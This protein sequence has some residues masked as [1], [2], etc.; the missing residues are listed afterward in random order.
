[1]KLAR[2]MLACLVTAMAATLVC[3]GEE[4]MDIDQL[5]DWNDP[6]ASEIRFRGALA[7]AD[8]DARL[9]LLTQVARTY[10]LRRQ[11]DQAHA[12]LDEVQLQ[13]PAAGPRVRLRYL[14]ERGRSFN[15][16]GERDSARAR[17]VEAWE[18]GRS[19][20]ADALAIDAAHMVAITEDD[21]EAVAWNQRALEIATE[22]DEPKAQRWKGA[23]LNNLAV[24]FG[25]LG[26]W[27]E[28][29]DA[30][31]LSHDEYLAFGDAGN[32]R[33]ARWMVAHAQRMLGQPDAAL[34]A[35]RQLER[36]LQ[37]LGQPDGYVF[38]EIAELLETRGE[39]GQAARYFRLAADELSKDDALV[40]DEPERLARLRRLGN[41]PPVD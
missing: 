7:D 4:G 10:S 21:A 30:A 22:S 24:T 34:D 39:R 11:F 3:A 37:E 28:A 1:M 41:R 32:I 20:G 12:T 15:S 14:L 16:A 13:L 31:R 29:C 23:L 27:Q 26:R 35:Q 40:A 36:E 19:V 18:I 25:K 17:F 8:A 38:E 33:I 5:W 2:L 6:A 9:E